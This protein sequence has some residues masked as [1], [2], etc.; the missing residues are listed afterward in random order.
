MN[1]EQFNKSMQTI[2]NY[3]D[4]SIENIQIDTAEGVT[5]TSS[6]GLK[7]KLIVS[8][9]G[10][11]S[12][13]QVMAYGDIVIS[14][15]S[16]EIN[17]G[18]SSTFTVQLG[19][20]PTESQTIEITSNNSDI[21]ASPSSITFT[22]EDYNVAQTITVSA[23]EDD[24]YDNETGTLTLTLTSDNVEEK[25]ISVTV[26][27]N[28]EKVVACTGISLDVETAEAQVNK[29]I[30]LNATVTP[31][32][33]TDEIIWSAENE[34]CTVVD[35]VVTGVAEGSCVITATC[36]DYSDTC[37]VTVVATGTTTDNILPVFSTWT[38]TDG[39]TIDDD[40]SVTINSTSW[41]KGI[42]T[43]INIAPGDYTVSYDSNGCNISIKD[44][45]TNS[46]LKTYAP[47]SNMKDP[48][49]IKL[50]IPETTTSIY[51]SIVNSNVDKAY[52]LVNFSIV[53]A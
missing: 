49:T 16:L 53:P 35:G 15:S 32:D 19:E 20:A 31:S 14:V 38:A 27:D 48:S 46:G 41:N 51:I 18:E 45:S 37:T 25:T 47:N 43:T 24:D 10:T 30:T 8:D 2:K 22:S 11:L 44:G 33:C 23:S 4:S 7:F 52:S 1:K 9:D 21:T 50:T 36:G 29:T 6:S 3:V 42:N 34:N 5:L 17:E 13:E 39:V 26:I 28:D 40:Y 12:T